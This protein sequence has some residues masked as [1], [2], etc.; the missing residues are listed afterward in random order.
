MKKRP[1]GAALRLLRNR[2]GISQAEL[3]RRVK[4]KSQSIS[5]FERCSSLNTKSL[6]R[7]LDS[8]GANLID[9]HEA[10][11]YAEYLALDEVPEFPGLPPE[12]AEAAPAAAGRATPLARHTGVPVLGSDDWWQR[13][14]VAMKVARQPSPARAQLRRADE[15]G[16]L[17]PEALRVALQALGCSQLSAEKEAEAFRLLRFLARELADLEGS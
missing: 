6:F 15:Q 3:A 13:A 17:A 9:F 1:V 2:L 11:A 14:A 7:V 12:A 16:E 10:L 8:L 5:I 4:R